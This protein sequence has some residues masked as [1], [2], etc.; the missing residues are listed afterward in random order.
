[1]S[2]RAASPSCA[3]APARQRA[4]HSTPGLPHRG[5]ATSPRGC[6]PLPAPGRGAVETAEHG[7]RSYLTSEGMKRAWEGRGASRRAGVPPPL[8]PACSGTPSCHVPGGICPAPLL[9]AL[10]QAERAC[11]LYPALL[12]ETA[13][14]SSTK[15]EELL[16]CQGIF[17]KPWEVSVALQRCNRSQR[18]KRNQSSSTDQDLQ[19][20]TGTQRTNVLALRVPFLASTPLLPLLCAQLLGPQTSPPRPSPLPVLA[21][22]SQGKTPPC[23]LGF[24]LPALVRTPR[25]CARF[26]RPRAPSSR[27]R[28]WGRRSRGT[29]CPLRHPCAVTRPHARARSWH[30]RP[31]SAARSWN[32]L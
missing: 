5:S 28:T 19:Q 27:G 3:A 21:S 14:S 22:L 9:P 1:M 13:P 16:R 15:P 7:P 2:P 11:L 20:E 4:A 10:Q 29:R 25:C 6:W 8:L 26:E 24:M 12:V 23:S 30:C 18:A 32:M 17:S 31:S